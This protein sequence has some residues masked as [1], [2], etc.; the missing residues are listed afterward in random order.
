LYYFLLGLGT[1]LSLCTS[2]NLLVEYIPKHSKIVFSTL[3]LSF[4]TLPAL[5][6]PIYLAVIQQSVM[7]FLFVGFGLALAGA[8]LTLVWLP[9]SP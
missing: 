1:V 7:P 2:Y 8:F 5:A 4:Q 6:L 3:F 9:E